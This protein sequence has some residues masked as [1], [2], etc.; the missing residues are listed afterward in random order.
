MESIHLNKIKNGLFFLLLMV[1]FSVLSQDGFRKTASGLKFNLVLDEPGATA[2]VGQLVSLHMILSDV[3]GN[4]IKNSYKSGK[5]ILFPVKVSTF[6]GDIY[7][8][9]SLLSQGDSALFKI[10]ADS[11]YARVFRKEVPADLVGSHLDLN[12]RV[13]K[14]WDQKEREAELKAQVEEVTPQEKKRRTQE[15]LKIEAFLKKEGV[16]AKKSP[17]G[18]YYQIIKEGKGTSVPE[19]EKTL[20]INY[21]GKLLDGRVFETTYNSKDIGRPVSFV[22]GAGSV[23]EGWEDVVPLLKEGDY[24]TMVVPSH[25]AFGNHKKSELVKENTPLIFNMEIVGV[26]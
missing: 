17:K 2:K 24:V 20:V 23:I 19:N 8:A 10:P 9:V 26:R 25:L 14:I 18:V 16:E 3:K 4:E 5:P 7:E 11:M 12:V 15:V 22:L 13:F 6:E 21:E 1:G